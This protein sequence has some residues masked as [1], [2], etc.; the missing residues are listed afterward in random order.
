MQKQCL[1]I[2]T[3]LLAVIAGGA[4]KFLVQGSVV[5]STDGR[6]AIQLRAS[7]RDLILHE[8][9]TFLATIQQVT[10]GISEDNM[11]RIAESARKVG[12]GA[13]SEVP[14]TLVGK[15]PMEF[16]QLGFDTHKKFDQ[17]AMDAEDLGDGSHT[18]GQLSTL[19]Q[20]CVSCHA[21]YRIEL[22]AE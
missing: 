9:R 6:L 5:E 22:A 17:L 11:D 16:K 13:R 7:E 18:L 10:Q 19:I 14:G 20:N 8:M 3:I 15:L 12:S 4:Y 21:A 1:L 2:V